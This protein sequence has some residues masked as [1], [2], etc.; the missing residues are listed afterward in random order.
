MQDG[1]SN[2]QRL[3][4]DLGAAYGAAWDRSLGITPIEQVHAA[5]Q[6]RLLGFTAA[7][8]RYA[9]DHLPSKP[10]NIFEFRD[11]CRAAPK[12][13]VP[14]LEQPKANP[15]RVAELARTVR[16][17]MESPSEKDPKSWAKKLQ[18]RH[19]GGEKLGPHQIRAYR[20][21]LGIEGRMPWQ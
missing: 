6:G 12:K 9:L 20:E 1:R 3:F 17:A 4:D 5:W 7:D 2:I 11:L 8:V 16:S 21:A 13:A 14:Q 18:R 15:E 10:P 19:E